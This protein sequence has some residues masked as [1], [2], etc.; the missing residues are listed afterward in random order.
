MRFDHLQ[1]S[2]VNNHDQTPT[3]YMA[4]C[5][6]E[7][8]FLDIEDGCGSEFSRCP[9][10]DEH[11]PSKL[12][13]LC[14]TIN[15]I[16]KDHDEDLQRNRSRLN[17]AV[18][19]L[20]NTQKELESLAAV[21]TKLE[22][23]QKEYALLEQKVNA[24]S[25]VARRCEELT[26]QCADAKQQL[27]ILARFDPAAAEA[28][29]KMLSGRIAEQED[30]KSALTTQLMQA[31]SQAGR[32]QQ[33][34]DQARAELEG[35]QNRIAKLTEMRN[36][37]QDA[38]KQLL[39]DYR[40]LELELSAANQ[41]QQ[42][43]ALA[44][45]EITAQLEDLREKISESRNGELEQKQAERD[46]VRKELEAMQES[47]N[48]VEM[49]RESLENERNQLIL[50]IARRKKENESHAEKLLISQ[51]KLEQMQQERIQLNAALSVCL[52][53]LDLLQAE[54]EQLKTRRLPEA[55]ELQNQERQCRDELVQNVE[56]CRCQYSIYKADADKLREQL[57]KLEEAVRNERV[58]YDALTASCSASSKELESL[59]R[60]NAEL[61][62]N[63]D[64]EKLVIYR[65]QLEETQRQLEQIRQ[66]CDQIEQENGQ[67]QKQLEEGQTE[68]ARL[69]EL[70][71][72]HESGIEVTA[73]QLQ[74]LEFAGS[75]S[76]LHEV[77]VLEER[78]KLLEL[79]RK[80]LATSIANM[81][82][83]LGYVPLEENASLENQMRHEL[84]ELQLRIED[85]RCTILDCAKSINMEVR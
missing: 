80:K 75:E 36:R 47:R 79:V 49:E 74:E 60:Q 20:R 51:K 58:V 69:L 70:K 50:D 52:Q 68:R 17:T 3:L 28:E 6:V 39:T 41:E 43:L 22:T 64:E 54:V 11:L 72:R 66:E 32:L 38:S 61:R 15:D 84:R 59:E 85:F 65:K 57:P 13:W 46:Q 9:A 4:L 23:V 40:Q 8:L 35:V 55:E 7:S 77:T 48:A 83:V 2:I 76:F 44:K 14:R 16:Y 71:R 24:Q 78:V 31:Q 34:C 25:A 53:E 81:Y 62:N 42:Q 21:T 63:N 18:E 27:Q 1:A 30:V 19:K 82:Q 12:I 73:K 29:L 5:M 33:D 67:M 45:Q 37:T 10:G 56:Q 26:A